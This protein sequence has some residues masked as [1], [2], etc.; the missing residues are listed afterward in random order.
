MRWNGELGTAPRFLPF[1]GRV[2]VLSVEMGKSAVRGIFRVI[3]RVRFCHRCP[4][5]PETLRGVAQLA[6]EHCGQPE[7]R[8]CGQIADSHSIVASMWA[9]V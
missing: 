9:K 6:A 2:D 8:G 5:V 3:G 4:D 7:V 1:C